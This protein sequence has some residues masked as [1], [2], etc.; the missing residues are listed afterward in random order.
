MRRKNLRWIFLLIFIVQFAFGTHTTTAFAT[1]TINPPEESIVGSPE[2][3]LVNGPVFDVKP[4]MSNEI[5]IV[6]KNISSYTANSI[7]IYPVISNL[8]NNPLKLE[9]KYNSS[10]LAT[11]NPRAERTITIVADVDETAPSGTYEVTLNYTYFNS[12]GVKSQSSNKIYLKVT[13]NSAVPNFVIENYNLTP[14]SMIA[15]SKATATATLRNLGPLDMYDVEI[16]LDGLTP[17]SLSVNGV[18]SQKFKRVDA[19]T[20]QNFSFDIIADS[21]IAAGNYPLSYVL[22]YNDH[23]GKSYDFTQKI[24]INVGGTGA[25]K[26]SLEIQNMKEPDGTF[27]VNENFPI[28]FQLVN[29]G[30]NTA[31]NIRITATPSGSDG[32]VVPKSTSVQTVKT[33]E[34]GQKQDFTFLFAATANSKSQNYAVEFQV[35]YEDGTKKEGADNVVTFKQYAGAN[36][37]NPEG[38]KKE[39]EEEKVSKPKIIVSNYVCDPLIVMA[40]S[41]FD[42]TMTFLNTHSEKSVKNI[43]MFLTLAE[44]KEADSEKTGN[45]FTPVNSSNTFYFDS[46]SSKGT[47]DKKMRLYVVPDAQPKTYTLTVNF[48]YEDA[49]GNEFTATELLGINVKQPTELKTGEI[50][51]PEMVEMGMP[52]SVSFEL[53]NTGKV[54]LNNLMI[55]LEGDIT[56]QAKDTYLG[57]FTSGYSEYY[58][59]SFSAMQEGENKVNIIISYDDPS[60]EHIEEKHEFVMTATP[61]MPMEEM[62]GIDGIDK[63]GG[64]ASGLG[65]MAG[66]I[67]IGIGI[68]LIVIIILIVVIKKRKAK[69]EAEFLAAEDF[70]EP[71]V[72][73]MQ[74]N[75]TNGKGNDANEQL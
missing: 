29:T 43:K 24:F 45:I 22:K 5:E 19:G 25:G 30:E 20:Q 1:D 44:E 4:G 40:G 62:D 59:G 2:V 69:K 46:I 17:E 71:E 6:L 35:E 57:N 14:E 74:G 75:D 56:T 28:S 67:A 42:L 72:P 34:K 9:F 37:S 38:D 60:G 27:G 8:E 15:G 21:N 10:R 41:E 68:A 58:E 64:N 53:Y 13:N 63:M 48:E 16:T 23:T 73:S 49:D 26:P 70:D 32:S 55:T 66:K 47:V 12:K 61:P 18:N 11:I 54:T 50:F 33:L 39:G 7:V 65:A 51:V 52:V 3:T 36:V 31:K